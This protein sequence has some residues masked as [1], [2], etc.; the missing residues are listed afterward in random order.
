MKTF[1][2][3][4]ALRA[5]WAVWKNN[6]KILILSTLIIFALSI[7]ADIRGRGVFMFAQG[8]ALMVIYNVAFIGW[9]KLLLKLKDGVHTSLHELVEHVSLFWKYVGSTILLI[10]GAGVGLIF[11]V[12][13]GIYF[14]LR[15]YFVTMLV[16]DK[17]L[18]IKEAFKESSL[19]TD[20][21]KW[22]I[23]VFL[24]A[25]VGLNILG[26]LALGVGLLVSAPVTMLAYIHIY[27]QLLSKADK[28]SPVVS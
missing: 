10:L 13:P 3:K 15:Y 14:I 20:G 7:L 25:S 8:L 2:I 12:V 22:K 28:A 19:M 23:L 4:E 16:I 18:S 27:R 26:V 11:L 21:V 9:V 6:E 17:N 24:L 5:G 1:S